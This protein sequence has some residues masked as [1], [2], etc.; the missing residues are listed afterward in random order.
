MLIAACGNVVNDIFDEENDR[1]NNKI[2]AGFSRQKAINWFFL[3]FIITLGL[4]FYISKAINQVYLSSIALIAIGCLILYS[5]VL[6]RK[7]LL[8]NFIVSL[9]VAFVPG[10]V[11][12]AERTSYNAL[13]ESNPSGHEYLTIILSAYMVFAFIANMFREIV[14]DIEDVKGDE[15][16]GYRTIAVAWGV[17]RSKFVALFYGGFLFVLELCWAIFNPLNQ[18]MIELIL[19]FIMII[20]PTIAAISRT[21]KSRSILD[22]RKSSQTIKIVMG[23]GLLY[24]FLINMI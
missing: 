23:L 10:I 2:K 21:H 7:V 16:S 19:F 12:Y 6:Q 18:S 20:V 4:A 9:F 5:K 15:L 22:F 24:L 11:W 1:L 13:Q 14:K 3:L 17:K 8:G